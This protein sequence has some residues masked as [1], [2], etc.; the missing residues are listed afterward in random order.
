MQTVE[1]RRGGENELVDLRVV[2]SPAPGRTHIRVE[3]DFSRARRLAWIMAGI[4]VF[5]VSAA[6]LNELVLAGGLGVT[7]AALTTVWGGM[8]GLQWWMTRRGAGTVERV[9]QEVIVE[10]RR[11]RLDKETAP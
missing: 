3:H 5:V 1:W 10:A 11:L 8:R 7:V 4:P 9:A 6:A 2:M